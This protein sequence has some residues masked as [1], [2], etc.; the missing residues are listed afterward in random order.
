MGGNEIADSLTRDSSVQ[1]FVG[2]EPFLG[3]SRRNIK[4]KT[5]RWMEKQRLAL[6]CGPCSTQ[7]QAQELI[8]GPDLATG[9]QLI[10]L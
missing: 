2:P 5:E 6:W 3:V 1:R 8:S 9:A 7:G 4:K 10:V